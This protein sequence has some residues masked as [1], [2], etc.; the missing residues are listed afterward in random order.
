[1]NARD[2]TRSYCERLG[3]PPPSE[4]DVELLLERGAESDARSAE[5]DSAESLAE[6]AGHADVLRALRRNTQ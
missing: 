6:Q 3:I 1:M 2:W 5:G 4:E